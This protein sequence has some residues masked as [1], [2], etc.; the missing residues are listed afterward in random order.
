MN[1]VRRWIV[2]ALL[3]PLDYFVSGFLYQTPGMTISSRCGF[4]LLSSEGGWKNR[5]L[6]A[7]GR[8]LNRIDDG[9]CF[10]A[11]HGDIARVERTLDRLQHWRSRIR[12]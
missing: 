2:N 6:R 12:A 10:G 5:C 1:R 11:I 3:L 9:H 4:A 7:L 8:G